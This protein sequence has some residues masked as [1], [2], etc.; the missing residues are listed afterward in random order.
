MGLLRRPAYACSLTVRVFFRFQKRIP[1]GSLERNDEMSLKGPTKPA[2]L[3]DLL[4]C[5]PLNM[6]PKQY[7]IVHFRYILN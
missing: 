2:D 7:K 3:D 5:S 1:E 6:H 4:P